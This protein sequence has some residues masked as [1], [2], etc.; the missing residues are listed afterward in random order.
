MTYKRLAEEILKLPV[1]LQETDATVSCD[2][3]EEAFFP[4]KNLYL[5]REGDFL[6][7]VLDIPHPVLTIYF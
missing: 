2:I 6:D 4:V 7:G 1:E 3:S 5:T